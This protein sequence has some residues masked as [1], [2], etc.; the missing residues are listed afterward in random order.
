MFILEINGNTVGLFIRM[1]LRSRN[2]QFMLASRLLDPLGGLRRQQ[3]ALQE[4]PP[5]R[6]LESRWGYLWSNAGGAGTEH[7]RILG[8]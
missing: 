4:R 5:L 2:Y 1:A 3:R 7:L 6:P 8:R